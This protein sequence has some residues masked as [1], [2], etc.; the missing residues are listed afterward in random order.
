VM[1]RV[2]DLAPFQLMNLATDIYGYKK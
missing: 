1:S 2:P